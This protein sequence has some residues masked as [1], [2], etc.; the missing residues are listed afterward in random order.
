MEEVDGSLAEA[1]SLEGS[2]AVLVG[3]LEEGLREEALVV[4]GVIHVR[5][6]QGL[7]PFPGAQVEDVEE[8]LGHG[9]LPL[10]ELATGL[11]EGRGRLRSV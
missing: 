1:R 9:E 11:V 6:A 2:H 7:E 5:V 10:L 8:L 3:G 4:A